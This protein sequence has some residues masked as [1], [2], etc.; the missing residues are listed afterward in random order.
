M[1]VKWLVGQDLMFL[2][3]LYSPR[4]WRLFFL[5]LQ[6]DRLARGFNLTDKAGNLQGHGMRASLLSE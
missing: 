2:L 4:C 6:A 3:H 1:E 5:E